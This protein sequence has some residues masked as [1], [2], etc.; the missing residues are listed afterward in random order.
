MT[1]LRLILVCLIPPIALATVALFVHLV[2]R[3]RRSGPE[4]SPSTQET[5][6]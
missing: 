4:K 2:R 5:Y 1:V 6:P 3:A